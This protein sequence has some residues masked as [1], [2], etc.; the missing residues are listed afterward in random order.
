VFMNGVL[1][2]PALLHVMSVAVVVQAN[3]AEAG[4]LAS[5]AAEDRSAALQN[6]VRVASRTR[7][8]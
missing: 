1:C 5:S 7:S 3:C 8:L 6:A 2:V 4:E